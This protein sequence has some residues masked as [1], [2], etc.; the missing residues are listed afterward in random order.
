MANQA[1]NNIITGNFFKMFLLDCLEK[2]YM[3]EIFIIEKIPSLYLSNKSP[4]TIP[5]FEKELLLKSLEYISIYNQDFQK[6]SAE[7]IY[8][9]KDQINL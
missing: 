5:N 3:K 1:N 9:N 8:N 7:F 6:L 4:S 2:L